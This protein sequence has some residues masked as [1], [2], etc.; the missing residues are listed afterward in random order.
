MKYLA[1][2]PVGAWLAGCGTTVIGEGVTT[3]LGGAGGAT[4]AITGGGTDVHVTTGGATLATGGQAAETGGATAASGGTNRATG[5]ASTATGGRAVATGGAV[6]ST[7]GSNTATGGS[8]GIDYCGGMIVASMAGC[9]LDDAYCLPLSDGRYCT[10]GWSAPCPQGLSSLPALECPVDQYWC[11]QHSMATACRL[12][13]RTTA[14]CIA[15]GGIVQGDPGDGSLR[16]SGCASPLVNLG[17]VDASAGDEGGICCGQGSGTADGPTYCGGGMVATSGQ[18]IVDDGFCYQLSNGQ[19]CTGSAAPQCPPGTDV[20]PITS[21][22][23]NAYWCWPQGL[24]FACTLPTR[25]ADECTRAGGEVHNDP[26]DGSV[27]TKGCQ[28]PLIDLGL[29]RPGGIEGS[30]CCGRH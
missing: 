10:D 11:W 28:S 6:A 30:I 17:L 23:E 18:C 24:A 4:S 9:L 22:P 12:P 21:C 27:V 26:G 7:G 14:E 5:G 29:V 16:R 13:L 3:H 8:R 2:I 19:Y 1:L 25:T 15:A 20:I